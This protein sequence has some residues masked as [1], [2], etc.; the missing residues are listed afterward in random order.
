M[1]WDSG[2]RPL[3]E[4]NRGGAY[5]SSNTNEYVYRRGDVRDVR[6]AAAFISHIHFGIR[7][8]QSRVRRSIDSRA[9]EGET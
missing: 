9:R 4:L 6:L 2:L 3:Q 1:T 8:Q 7:E 5:T